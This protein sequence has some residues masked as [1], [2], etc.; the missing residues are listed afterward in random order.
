MG[1]APPI[2]LVVDDEAAV[3]RVAGR[4]VRALGYEVA[5]AR[6]LAAARERASVGDLAVA[7]VDL[8]LGDA[9]GAAVAV[10]LRAAAP[11]L[12]L[13]FASGLVDSEVTA[14][15]A[16]WGPVLEKPF[17]REKLRTTLAAAVQA[18]GSGPT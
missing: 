6:T 5:E 17:D 12:P 4:L 7:L 15:L 2:V 18:R 3:L 14:A 11:D 8:H 1:S 10:G 13:V 9:A 16:A